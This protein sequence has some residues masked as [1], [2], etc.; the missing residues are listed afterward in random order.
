MERILP[1]R[2]HPA[3]TLF[4]PGILNWKKFLIALFFGFLISPSLSIA[5]TK[6]LVIIKLDGLPHDTVERYVQERDPH[7]GKSQL[8]WIEHIFYERGT[9]LENFYVR[10]IS[11]SGPSWSMLD[12]GQHLQIKGNVDFD[13]YSLHAYDYLNMIPFF[14][15]GAAGAQ[16]DM[17]G[18]Q[19][20]DSL[21]IPLLIDAY[22]HQERYSGFSIYQR[23]T[24]YLTFSNGLQNRFKRG[25]KELFDEWTMGLELRSFV[26]DELVKELITKLQDPQIHYLDLILQD[27][28]HLAHHNGDSDSQLQVLKE[29]DEVIGQV[30]TAIQHSPGA[31]DTTFVIVSDHGINTHEQVYSQGYNLVK[32]LGS[33]AGG[34]HHV[35]TKRRLMLDYSIKGINP[36]YY[37]ISTS[38]RDSYY[39][40]GQSEDYPTAMMDFDGNER[41]SIHLR[42]SD[43]NVLH[44]ILQ[45]LRSKELSEPVRQA[46]VGSFFA[47]LKERRS[48]WQTNSEQLKEEL[49]ALHR[50]IEKQS[51]LGRQQPK[52]LTRDELRA[53]RDD[54]VHRVFAQLKRWE[55]QERE[56]STYSQALTNLLALRRENF[57]PV[58]LQIE[59]VIPKHAMGDR[60][61]IYE[62]QNYV[63]GIPATGLALNPDGSLDIQKSFVRVNYFSLLHQIAVRNNVQREVSNRPVDFVATTI[64]FERLRSFF[65]GLENVERDVIWVY[66]G[67]EHQALILAREDEAGQL[68]FMYQ[69]VKALKQDAD[70]QVH[71]EAAAWQPGFPLRIIED[72]ALAVPAGKAEEW[73]SQWHTDVEWLHALHKTQYSN[74]V[75]GLY[76][77]LGSHQIKDD[78]RELAGDELLMR[79]FAQHQRRLI[80]PDLLVIANNHWNFD[81]R[82]FNPGGNHGSF[83]RISTHST[84]MLAGGARTGIPRGLI[85][86]EPYDGLSFTPTMLA[87]TGKLGDDR[88]PVSAL[89][90][91]GFRR[92][93]GRV[94]KEVISSQ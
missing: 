29:L 63:V 7:T 30:W 81:V 55:E 70:G 23:G 48:E 21:G 50:A 53:G 3:R 17:V 34:G 86:N 94:V 8:P 40:K 22:P 28:D 67:P 39:L 25:P 45:Q 69:P 15:R 19:V 71:F 14:L 27:F 82:G 10:G 83:L 13:R 38:S 72:P 52:K 60:N 87:L 62:L 49:A 16:V 54:E 12:T 41:A 61:S 31:E 26:A 1:R 46:L 2:C 76:E 35:A 90:E 93:P 11:L 42:D 58:K 65:P 80:E 20:L 57:D 47:T 88:M 79:H 75:I 32:L 73:L 92:F 18:V 24:R 33:S 64:H 78:A 37:F 51:E 6:R 66:D 4:L 91:K 84:W 36:F 74:G 56:Y 68:S 89:R 77:T 85:V 59:D 5:Q 43:L 9:R 44:L